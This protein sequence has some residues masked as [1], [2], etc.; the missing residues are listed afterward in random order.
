MAITIARAESKSVAKATTE[1]KI[2]AK[3]K[4]KIKADTCVSSMH[5]RKYFTLLKLRTDLRKKY[6]S[7]VIHMF[8]HFFCRTLNCHHT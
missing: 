1:S 4:D 7:S 8:G 3:A 2:V 6:F 5:S